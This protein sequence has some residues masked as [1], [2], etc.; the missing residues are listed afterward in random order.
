MGQPAHLSIQSIPF[1][2]ETL[3]WNHKREWGGHRSP[4][5]GPCRPVLGNRLENGLCRLRGASTF[6]AL[7]NGCGMGPDNWDRTALYQWLGQWLAGCHPGRSPAPRPAPGWQRPSAPL[8]LR[9][10]NQGHDQ[11]RG[12]AHTVHPTVG[13]EDIRRRQH[14]DLI[15]HRLCLRTFA[16]S[17]PRAWRSDSPGPPPSPPGT[18]SP[19]RYV[20][21]TD[22]RAQVLIVHRAQGNIDGF[23]GLGARGCRIGR[24]EGSTNISREKVSAAGLEISG[25]V[26]D[27]KGRVVIPPK[28]RK[29]FFTGYPYAQADDAS[30]CEIFGTA[31]HGKQVPPHP[32]PMTFAEAR[33]KAKVVVEERKGIPQLFGPP[34]CPKRHGIPLRS[35]RGNPFHIKQIFSSRASVARTIQVN[36]ERPNP[37]PPGAVLREARVISNAARHRRTKVAPASE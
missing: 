5:L 3:L 31:H 27:G 35:H 4:C 10:A 12:L 28:W 36:V 6:P 25:G 11:K 2:R 8:G 30:F 19:L 17:G 14:P 37:C 26:D 24:R 9:A 20:G 21:R 16:G 29:H 33:L 1:A 15:H 13:E 34:A 22:K 7:G 23:C 18:A 32:C